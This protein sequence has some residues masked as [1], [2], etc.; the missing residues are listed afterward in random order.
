MEMM[1][2]ITHSECAHHQLKDTVDGQR[3]LTSLKDEAHI[4]MNQ[5]PTCHKTQ[6]L[7]VLSGTT[8][9]SLEVF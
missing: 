6:E 3:L 2:G 4:S 9:S 1:C 5:T 7:I 8:Q